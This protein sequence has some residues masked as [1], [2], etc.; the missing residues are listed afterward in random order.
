MDIKFA[1]L[2]FLSWK[3]VTGYELK[4]LMED[5]DV[6][7]WSGNNNQI[8]TALVQ[9]HK[10]GLVT[11]EIVMQEQLPAR[12]IYSIQEKGLQVL[13]EWL[14]ADPE[15]PEIRKK[16]LVQLA[17]SNQLSDPELDE[18]IAKYEFE[19]NMKLK[20]RQE[21]ERRGTNINPSRSRRENI[22]WEMIYRSY[23]T[24]YK[25]ELDWIQELRQKI[26]HQPNT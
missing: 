7:Y 13:R 10:E 11:N 20:L 18:I 12:K 14:R 8:Y 24:S 19:I 25:A 4:K 9:M 5:S 15:L 3:P 21:Q 2:G 17:W 6:F 22:I 23:I 16:F 26:A 1:I